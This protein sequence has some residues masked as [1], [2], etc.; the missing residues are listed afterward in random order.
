M[1][2]AGLLRRVEGE[3]HQAAAGADGLRPG[4]DVVPEDHVDAGLK[5][6]QPTL[7]R[8]V[9][10]ELTKAEPCLVVAE[11]PSQH[12]AEESKGIARR[13]AVAMLQA[14]IHHAAD[15]DAV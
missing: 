12:G 7:R 2:I 6:I 11:L 1:E 3:P 14:E 8:E 13:V 5:A 4:N 9:E 10:A 15:D